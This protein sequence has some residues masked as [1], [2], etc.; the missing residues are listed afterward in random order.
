MVSDR[1]LFQDRGQ[2]HHVQ[3]HDPQVTTHA[4]AVDRVRER[5]VGAVL[6]E[7]V[8]QDGT[9][10]H[11]H[12]GALGGRGRLDVLGDRLEGDGAHFREFGADPYLARLVSFL[13]AA[14]VTWACN[15]RYTFAGQGGASRSREWARYLLAM[16]AGFVLNYGSYAAL[17]ALSSL[18]CAWPAIGV[19]VGSVAGGVLNFLTSKYWI[20][21]ADAVR[22]DT[23]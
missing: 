17:V 19:A 2:A 14:S 1:A 3:A 11:E 18:V 23:A 9:V 6:V 8:G 12:R 5:H 4:G 13:A 15:R 20:F 21:R 7:E 16:A 10:R 22:S